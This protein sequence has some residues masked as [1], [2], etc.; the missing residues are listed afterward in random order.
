MTSLQKRLKKS[1]KQEKLSLEVLQHVAGDCF[2][3]TYFSDLGLTKKEAA[4]AAMFLNKS[5]ANFYKDLKKE[6]RFI[7]E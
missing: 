6:F 3:E 2:F 1:A 7:E 5:S 4:E